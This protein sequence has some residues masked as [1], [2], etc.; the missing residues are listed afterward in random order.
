MGIEERK[1][2]SRQNLSGSIVKT[3]SNARQRNHNSGAPPVPIITS[4]KGF[5]SSPS[6]RMFVCVWKEGRKEARKEGRV[7]HSQKHLSIGKTKI[8]KSPSAQKCAYMCI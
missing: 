5:G 6:S 1:C 7:L 8:Y 2:H 4:L 3:R